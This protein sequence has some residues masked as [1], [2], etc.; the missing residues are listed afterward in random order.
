MLQVR[1]LGQFDVRSDGRKVPIASRAGQSLFAFL[2]LSAGTEHRREKL[3][4]QFWPDTSDDNARHNL[5]QELWRLRKALT[6]PSGS[7]PEY[8]LTEDISIAFNRDA[9]Y[10][11]D[12]AQLERAH[13][14]NS[15]GELM[16][17]VAL[18][19]GE[20]LPG[21]YDDWV[22]L[23]RERVQVLFERKIQEL[24]ERLIAEQQWS[25]VLEWAERWIALGQT[26]EPAY[27]AL[28]VA[29]GT[30][31]DTAKVIL[32]YERCVEAMRNEVGVEPSAETRALFERYTHGEIAA[33]A[34][35][36]GA[37]TILV[38]PS[39]TVTFLFTDIE[40]STQL[41]ERLGNDYA[42][43]LADQRDLLHTTAEKFNGH[44]VDSQG[45]AFFFAFFRAADAVAF[46]AAAQ[47]ALA[48]HPWPRGEALRVR[49]GL[50]TGEP[51]LARTGYVGMDVH[52]AARIGAAGHGGQVLLS[53]TTRALVENELPD[54]TG[55]L[56][57]GEH[58][59]KDLRYPV[60]IVQLTIE[61]LPSDFPPLKS[62]NTGVEPP[63][64]GE[65]P[66]KGLQFFDE[67]DADLFFGREPLVA[68]LAEELRANR[69]L[70]V[71]VGASGSGKSSVVRAGLIPALRNVTSDATRSQGEGRSWQ[72]YVMTPTAHPLEA[73]ATILTRD[74]ESLMATAALLDDLSREP[75]SLR[76]FIKRA[77]TPSLSAEGKWSASA[78]QILLVVDQ[79]EE[80]F[81]LCR[82]DFEREAFIDNLL[83]A[84][85]P[86][87][88]AGEGQGDGLLTLVITI[89]ADFYAHLAQYP[90]LRDAVAKQQEYIGP[91][92]AE[93]LRRAIEEPARSGG[94]EFE[95]GLVDLILRDVGEE[96]GALPLLSHAL[97]ETWKRRSGHLMTLKGYAD[98]G[99][100]RG[101]IAHTAETTFQQLTPEQ[102][103]IARNI[104]LR[105]TELGE[106]TE[107]T[108]R[109]A[110][111]DELIPRGAD[112][113]QVRVVLTRLADARLITTSEN[114]A[115]VAHEALIREWPRLRE[116]L[117][118]D[119]EG[120]ILHRRLTEAAQEW[121]LLEHDTGALYRGGRLAQADE[122]ATANPNALN[123][124]ERA[125]LDASAALE[126]QEL[127]EKEEQRQ[128]ELEAAEQLLTAEKLRVEQQERANARLRRRAL[129]LAGAFIVALLMAGAALYFGNRANESAAKAELNALAASHAQA[130]AVADEG[131]AENS[132]LEADGQ[133]LLAQKSEAEAVAQQKIATAREL[134][135]SAL[136]QIG[137]DPERAI[138]LGL[139]SVKTTYD[140]DKS[141]LPE[142]AN[143]LHRAV[144]GSQVEYVL[145]GLTPPMNAV[146]FSPD[147][148]RLVAAN[149]NNT[150]KVYDST[151]GKEL[152]T[153]SGHGCCLHYAWLGGVVDANYSP[154]G[155]RIVTAGA[156][157][158]TARVWDAVTGKQLHLL[159]GT[160]RGI[161][162][163]Q[164][165]P[166]GKHI[167]TAGRDGTAIIWDAETGAALLSKQYDHPPD[168]GD[169]APG[170]LWQA[171]FSP[172][173]KFVATAGGERVTRVWDAQTG[174]Q[175]FE[176]PGFW[177][178]TAAFSPDS[179]LLAA[180]GI[181]GTLKIWDLNTKKE[182]LSLS[183][184]NSAILK[185][186]FSPDGKQI[187][188]AS[189]DGTVKLS[190][191]QTGQVLQTFTGH[192]GWVTS[193][194]FSP[195][196]ERL[197]ASG[198]DGSAIIWDLAGG[199]PIATIRNPFDPTSRLE[200]E[201]LQYS[202]DSKRLLVGNTDNT[203][204]ATAKIFSVDSKTPNLLFA[205]PGPVG[206]WSVA[207]IS[208]DG[209]R[210]G[211]R[212]IGKNGAT[213]IRIWDVSGNGP[214]A[215][216]VLSR[217]LPIEFWNDAGVWF[218]ANLSRI[219]MATPDGK[220]HVFD[221]ASG[222]PLLTFDTGFT[223][224]IAPGP[225]SP[226]GKQLLITAGKPPVKVWDLTSGKQVFELSGHSGTT[227]AVYSP[228]G[229]RIASSGCDGTARI[230]D[231][232][233][234]ELLHTIAVTTQCV[235]AVNFSGD[236]KQL[237]TGDDAATVKV[238]DAAT[239]KLLYTLLGHND[240]VVNAVIRPDGAQIASTGGDGTVHLWSTT[241]RR[242]R[243]AFPG[244]LV[245]NGLSPDGKQLYT[246]ESGDAVT[247]RRFDLTAARSP[248]IAPHTTIP[249]PISAADFEGLYLEPTGKLLLGP[250]AGGN[251]GIWDTKTGKEVL[252]FHA[253]DGDITATTLSPDGK[254]LL[255]VS[256]DGTAKV[257]D[258]EKS[259][260]DG[261]PPK[262]LFTLSGHGLAINFGLYSPDG[263]RIATGTS[264]DGVIKI[265]D[266]ATG[267]ELNTLTG[268]TSSIFDIEFSADGKRLASASRDATA[269]IWDVETGKELM[270]FVGHHGWL[271]NIAISHNGQWLATQSLDGTA[272]LWDIQ[273]GK[274]LLS[275]D[276]PS[277]PNYWGISF[278]PDDTRLYA[279]S[280]DG[281]RE[282]VLPIEDLMQLARSRVTRTL[283]DEECKEFLHVEKCPQ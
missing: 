143:A 176:Q 42:S 257:W 97:L 264:L 99:G 15:T 48:S 106:G 41:L 4:G 186:K 243:A 111:F 200:G 45:D 263:T 208:A 96:P 238:Y 65:P 233:T 167:V 90:E 163:A 133:R 16:S 112:G 137:V 213:L 234:G 75:R 81:T 58:K 239:T 132:K 72:I 242:E 24:L 124:H 146:A 86:S 164:F 129:L 207:Q 258:V 249:L 198:A 122:Y 205:I 266:A 244:V 82:D 235:T 236:G 92:T 177:S 254:H 182:L 170:A 179:R 250:I 50:H 175:V 1:L 192:S 262:E 274:E 278:S 36:S 195:D 229:K 83:T 110:S 118:E 11:L 144:Q 121:E 109:R 168:S 277:P 154:D 77:L 114:S 54:G 237:M 9:D 101:A 17:Q 240:T 100:V 113:E 224:P 139:Q 78:R 95:A 32:A 252:Y 98:A 73:L 115:E 35:L 105:L 44:E 180:G 161:N 138:W 69:F 71:V 206:V 125:F 85:A 283:T 217:T 84:L 188:T 276:T 68:K 31:G 80:L 89:R 227:W 273:T 130:T 70:A 66:F 197:A 64:P 269:K 216:E 12:V 88:A 30:V 172:D 228:D 25:I 155:T 19:R 184:H 260:L 148:T 231:A 225:F 185:V 151:T 53:E 280:Q 191:A 94:W 220:V 8:L 10:W 60:H 47:R 127:K 173:G 102:Q 261:S 39:G 174:D 193:V 3:A 212:D 104:F 59:L 33:P 123:V 117:N 270:T 210:L 272:K 43:L 255:D 46:A 169:M 134:A 203:Q 201:I 247:V 282:F 165:S 267:K 157:D 26:P 232:A 34:Q 253:H 131:A 162:S 160:G 108:R 150:V 28:M 222:T 159:K 209:K 187:A 189:A 142:A 57:L 37:P 183:D 55:L 5:R 218:D 120:L 149:Q 61:G 214:A 79:F 51:M 20:L 166:D 141:V 281:V 147:G 18:Y 178:W 67:A 116:W 136:N 62:V 226:D 265:W 171:V 91:M 153:L 13:A 7:D 40:G 279:S 251:V 76:L 271:N 221:L 268:H 199:K 275:L 52:R 87:M 126:E 119:R 140:T 219:A 245:Y 241:L 6:T 194:D 256:Q 246:A 190:D 259:L 21:F 230:W 107:D 49:M 22:V 14:D 202:P 56:D 23:E 38:Q 223:F 128:R 27:R 74:S 158:N 29:H 2:L 93:E 156:G 196:G 181:S 211:T 215:R 248:D 152:L 135:A 204:E 63:A 145:T 103:S